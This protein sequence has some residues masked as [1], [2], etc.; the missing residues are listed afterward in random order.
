M[1]TGEFESRVEI[2]YDKVAITQMALDRPATPQD[3]VVASK[4]ADKLLNVKNIE[5]SFALM[6]MGD[7]VVVSAR[8][9][10]DVNVQLILERLSGGGH[11]DIAGAQLK[12]S[13][14]SKAFAMLTDAIQDYFQYDYKSDEE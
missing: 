9:K 14:L 8:S 4:V 7:D 3:R 11:F 13:T 5:A 6:Q 10:G 2:F 1:L 12:R